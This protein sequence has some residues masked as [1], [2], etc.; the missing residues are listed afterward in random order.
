MASETLSQDQIDQMLGGGARPA[1][2][3]AARRPSSEV[4]VYDFRRPH[5][6]SKERL[7]S[8]EAM[9]ERLGKT[10]EGW[11]IGRVRG[12]VEVRL[13]SVEQ[14]S[15]GEFILSLSTPCASFI[16]DVHDSG[17][18]QGVIDLGP[19]FC[20]FLID[21]LFGGTGTPAPLTRALTA[22]ERD[23]VRGTVERLLSGLSEI[24]QD[25][26]PLQLSIAGFESAPEIL[27][28]ARK[29]D[30]VLV[31]SIEVHAA[32]TSSLLLACLPFAVLDKY[33]ATS[34]QRRVNAG[35]GSERE[36]EQNR[37]L[38]ESQLRATRVPVSARLPEFR[39]TMRA[40]GSLA[41]GGVISTGIPRDATLEVR[42]GAQDRFRAAPGRV[43]RR[44]A[45]RVLD[46]AGPAAE[47]R[48]TS[49]EA[50]PAE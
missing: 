30:P 41:V 18:P 50:P 35:T 45:V 17:G 10:L 38:T 11:L 22:I 12:Q 39:M 7:R 14:L 4:Q 44:L 31:A 21:R 1:G 5:R 46:S 32:G 33:F 47:E 27:Q 9:Y 48:P 20:G 6:V 49:R 29:E 25:H 24:W 2:G 3:S 8:L 13:Q 37:E 26:V 28:V 36:R 16:V 19:E 40:L 42:V 23:A 15:F 34:E 43:G